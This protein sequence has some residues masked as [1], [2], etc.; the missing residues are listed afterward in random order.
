M[1]INMSHLNHNGDRI[2]Q[3]AIYEH[4]INHAENNINM[5]K[6]PRLE[7][8]IHRQG[9]THRHICVCQTDRHVY[10]HDRDQV[11]LSLYLQYFLPPLRSSMGPPLP[12]LGCKQAD[13]FVLLSL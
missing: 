3:S 7:N 8:V 12:H 1:N 2:T 4:N 10:Q 13:G 6:P 11:R 9:K 5:K